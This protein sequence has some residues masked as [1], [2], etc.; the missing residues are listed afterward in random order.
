[1]VTCGKGNS[2][3]MDVLGTERNMPTFFEPCEAGMREELRRAI[4]ADGFS[5][6]MEFGCGAVRE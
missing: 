1:M 3:G 2:I 5:V 6:F 4:I